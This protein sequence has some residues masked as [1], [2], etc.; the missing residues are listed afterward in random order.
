MLTKQAFAVWSSHPPDHGFLAAD[1]S[2]LTA[3]R[4]N[5]RPVTANYD[6]PATIAS[7]TVIGAAEGPDRAVVIAD[8]PD[9]S[10][11]VATSDAAG[12]AQDMTGGEW[13]GRP[14]DIR[15]ATFRPAD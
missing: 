13:C 12:L 15:A 6:G 5:T 1:A 2:A 8:L 9:G 7:Y 4:T 11:T 10:R 14:I 3:Q